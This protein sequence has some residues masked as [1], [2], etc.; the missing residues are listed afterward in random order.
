ME[1]KIFQ[2]AG[3]DFCKKVRFGVAAGSSI[4]SKGH[5]MGGTNLFLQK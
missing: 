2:P 4:I 1:E 5:V 3:R